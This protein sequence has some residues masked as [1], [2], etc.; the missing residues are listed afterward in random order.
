MTLRKGE[1]EDKEFTVDIGDVSQIYNTS[2]IKLKS[3][4]NKNININKTLLILSTNAIP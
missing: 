3:R 1:G 4:C 2:D